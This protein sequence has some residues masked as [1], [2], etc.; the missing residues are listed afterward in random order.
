MVARIL[1]I[2]LLISLFIIY[3]LNSFLN[4]KDLDL[5]NVTSLTIT[6][7]DAAQLSFDIEDPADKKLIEKLVNWYAAAKPQSL[8]LNP[9]FPD[10]TVFTWTFKN[11]QQLVMYAPKE[12]KG[13]I[14]VKDYKLPLVYKLKADPSPELIALKVFANNR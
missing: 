8:A 14:M 12:F 7:P 13:N 11:G 3:G 4:T 10:F 1:G 5:A 9:N 2:F 6:Q